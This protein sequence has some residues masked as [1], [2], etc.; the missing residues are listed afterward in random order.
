MVSII[1]RLSGPKGDVCYRLL[2]ECLDTQTSDVRVI[3]GSA[4]TERF[5]GLQNQVAFVGYSANVQQVMS[6]S[7]LVIGA[8]RVA[9][10]ALMCGRPTLAV[11][12]ASCV[13]LV[14]SSNLD[15]AMACNIGDIGSNNLA[16]GFSSVAGLVP[17]C[18]V[19][20]H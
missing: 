7:D 11:G 20:R 16:I 5:A 12:E 19:C 17:N 4:M 18:S 8:G 3:T 1:G 14:D 9:M 13:G 2:T 10:K 15:A 6:E